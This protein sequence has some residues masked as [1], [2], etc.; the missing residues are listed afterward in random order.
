MDREHRDQRD[1]DNPNENEGER[2]SGMDFRSISHHHG[3]AD[4]TT[5]A[6]SEVHFFLLLKSFNSQFLRK[7]IRDKRTKKCRLYRT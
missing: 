4:Q 3:A 1:H 5:D 2:K 7:S 6:D